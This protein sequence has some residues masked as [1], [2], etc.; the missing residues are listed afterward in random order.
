MNSEGAFV[1]KL[2]VDR[3]TGESFKD[4]GKVTSDKKVAGKVTQPNKE[5][6]G[7]KPEK[8]KPAWLLKLEQLQLK[9]LDEMSNT[10]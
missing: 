1:P 2:H 3:L 10:G 8:Q 5:E 4:E 7:K 6:T 9:S